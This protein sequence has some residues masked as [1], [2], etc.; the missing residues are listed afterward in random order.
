MAVY[1]QTE[2]FDSLVNNWN[3]LMNRLEEGIA[4]DGAL[5]DQVLESM[6]MI[7]VRFMGCMYSV[8]PLRICWT[9]ILLAFSDGWN[10]S[11]NA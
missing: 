6:A 1:I 2:T 9:M 4:E 8:L 11:Q 7:V 5:M 3:T 10:G